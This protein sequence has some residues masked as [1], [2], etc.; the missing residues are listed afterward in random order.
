MSKETRRYKQPPENDQ[1]KTNK[2]FVGT[3]EEETI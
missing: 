3:H 2:I 1:K